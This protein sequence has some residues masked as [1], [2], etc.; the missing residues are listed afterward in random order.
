MEHGQLRDTTR[1]EVIPKQLHE[2]FD[3]DEA[4]IINTNM[5]IGNIHGGCGAFI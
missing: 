5:G 4:T 3:K 2:I 1:T